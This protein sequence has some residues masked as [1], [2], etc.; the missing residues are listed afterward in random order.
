M[1][2]DLVG[3][4][5]V[6]KIDARTSEKTHEQRGCSSGITNR[7][8]VIVRLA[9]VR[10]D[11]FD[12]PFSD[13]FEGS[14]FQD[15]CLIVSIG[16]HPISESFADILLLQDLF[17]SGPRVIGY[18]S[19]DVIPTLSV[20]RT[21][22]SSVVNNGSEEISLFNVLERSKSAFPLRLCCRP[23]IQ[24]ASAICSFS[25]R[26]TV[27]SHH[28]RVSTVLVKDLGGES[29][30]RHRASLSGHERA[31][32]VIDLTAKERQL[33][34]QAFRSDEIPVSVTVA[35]GAETVQNS[36]HE[37]VRPRSSE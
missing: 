32:E 31:R 18:M 10:M 25:E 34:S 9:E 21:K 26:L 36:S 20:A 22:A 11:E 24:G 2:R 16:N 13:Q 4:S 28:Q 5:M 7:L 17:S 29:G 1:C 27:L 37:P 30:S 35:V 12:V 8:V 15:R 19:L 3:L 14:E 23:G 33:I 6:S